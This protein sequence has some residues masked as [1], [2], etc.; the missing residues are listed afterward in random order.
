MSLFFRSIFGPSKFIPGIF[1]L[2]SKSGPLT[3]GPF[4][5]IFGPLILALAPGILPL[6][7]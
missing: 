1:P 2:I 6:R 5:S 3:L 4:I 7:L